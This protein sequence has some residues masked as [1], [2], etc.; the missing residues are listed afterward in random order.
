[1][2]LA[3]G[4][5]PSSMGFTTHM[6]YLTLPFAVIDENCWSYKNRHYR[7]SIG[8]ALC[9]IRFAYYNRLETTYQRRHLMEFNKE[10]DASGL[11]CPLPIVKT[12]K[13]LAD[14]TPGHV[15]RVIST[16]PGSVC[17]M[18]AFAEQTGNTLLEQ[19]NENSK[20]VFYLKKA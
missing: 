19:A 2:V 4:S 18:A 12:K 15:L 16:D 7:N 17:D 6:G 1:M 11:A 10:F 13:A 20:F 8:M 5:R 14:M 3:T 9:T